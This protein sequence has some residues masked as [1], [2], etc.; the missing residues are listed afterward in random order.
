VA[1]D[2]AL[3][4]HRLLARVDDLDRVLDRQDV[5]GLRAV[6]QVDQRRQRRGLAVAV[7]PGD[8]HQALVVGRDAGQL[9]G[10]AELLERRRRHRDQPE[11]AL[12]AA[13]H[14]RDVGAQP[15]GAGDV[16]RA[17][18]VAAVLERPPL[19]AVEQRR[20]HAL[21]R[22]GAERR[23]LGHERAQDARHR[24]PV[25]GDVEIGRALIAR[26]PH[27]RHERGIA[28]ADPHPRSLG[29]RRRRGW[30]GCRGRHVRHGDRRLG[31]PLHAAAALAV[32]LGRGVGLGL[33]A[34][35]PRQP[36][37]PLVAHRLDV[38]GDRLALEGHG[39]AAQVGQ[40]RR[41]RRAGH[42]PLELLEAEVGPADRPELPAALDRH[43][44]A[45]GQ[46]DLGHVVAP[47]ELDQLGQL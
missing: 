8:H 7:G 12:P 22:G 26:R 29:G 43:R 33:A 27:Q 21:D 23:A 47:E 45:G 39:A 2:L 44:P 31:R 25:G 10:Q 5:V 14:P 30:R 11:A 38:D 36:H 17:V 34:G 15:A 9:L 32:A 6:D 35:A 37:H 40:E 24:R 28:L 4:H 18:D 1:A 42:Q 20:Q 3:R 19:I 16:E 13:A 41:Q 46:H